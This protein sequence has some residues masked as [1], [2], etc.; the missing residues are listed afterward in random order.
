LIWRRGAT[1]RSK[2]EPRADA[3]R[4]SGCKP[5]APTCPL[6]LASRIVCYCMFET[7]S[8]L[9]LARVR[10]WRQGL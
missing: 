8:G 9:R 4:V 7:A 1:A 2:R 6:A 5:S 3:A 10:K